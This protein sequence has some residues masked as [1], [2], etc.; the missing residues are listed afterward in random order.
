MRKRGG[1]I[2]I[3]DILGY[4]TLKC[5]LHLHTVF[6]D[7]TVWP[8]ERVEEAWRKGLDAVAITDHIENKYRIYL[9]ALFNIPVNKKFKE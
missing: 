5:D 8:A 2:K 7:G 6:S 9:D 1:D 4:K 3:P